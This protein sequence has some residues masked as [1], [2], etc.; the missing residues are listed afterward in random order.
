MRSHA[1]VGRQRHDGHRQDAEGD[2]SGGRV[3]DRIG[4]GEEPLHPTNLSEISRQFDL[5]RDGQ[6]HRRDDADRDDDDAYHVRR[7]SKDQHG[8]EPA[9]DQRADQEHVD[10]VHDQVSSHDEDQRGERR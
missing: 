5:R 4:E 6:S 8:A 2:R 10:G 7:E 3:V 9:T 1:L